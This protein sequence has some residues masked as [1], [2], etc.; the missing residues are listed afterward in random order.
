MGVLFQETPASVTDSETSSSAEG[1]YQRGVAES[2][3]RL[4]AAKQRSFWEKALLL[5]CSVLFVYSS[6]S[7]GH[8]HV[9]AVSVIAA[10]S[11]L[12]AFYDYAKH[13][14]DELRIVHLCGFYE[15]GL[16][17]L[18]RD[19]TTLERTGEEYERPQHLYQSDLQILGERSLFSLMCTTRSEAGAERLTDYLLDPVDI[20]EARA[21]QEAV[22]ELRAMTELREKIALLGKYQFQDCDAET[23]REW[24][25]APVFRVPWVFPI[26]LLFTSMGIVLLTIGG[27][28]QPQLWNHITSYLFPLIG[29]QVIACALVVL[30]VRRRM[31]MT[32]S[33]A[34][35]C[36]VLAEGLRLLEEQA[37]VSSKLKELVEKAR[38]S[39]ASQNIRWL[40]RLLWTVAQHDKNGVYQVS[41]IVAAGTQLVLAV[42]RWRAK[43][44]EPFREWLAIWAEFDALNAIACYAWENPDSVFPELEDGAALL[45]MEGVGHPLLPANKCVRNDVVLD[46]SERF[47]VLSG[48]NMA[49]KS[50]LLRAVG[51]NAVLAYAGAPVRASHARLCGF[52][53]CSSISLSDSLL[54]GKSKFLAE[55]ERLQHIL[56]QTAA[57]RPVLF[58][59]DEILSGTNSHDRRIAC[60]S[61]VRAL[62]AGGAIG[63]LSTH[64]L[65]LTEIARAPELRG[66]N[67]CM[68]EEDP[69]QLLHF[70][71]VVKPGVTRNRNA[72]AILKLLGVPADLSKE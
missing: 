57:E 15:R 69:N 62:V 16:E 1:G 3:E 60:E 19:W 10:L 11:F 17:R 39:R 12:A 6:L 50:T 28:V 66:I 29:A 67:R 43:Y 71:Y 35:E 68:E 47:W 34:T 38:A 27:L 41:L 55:A 65:A 26:F 40:E 51:M 32:R 45:H 23:L 33:V 42:E 37:F 70:D 21:R 5:G 58:L 30:E 72:L 22:R 13:R 20:V 9:S 53:V 14:G 7:G 59:I 46:E 49:G 63:I 61:I 52:T 8:F 25:G 48:S 64:D 24:M 31:E 4:S 18:R 56:Q 36:S 44:R 54:D 2:N